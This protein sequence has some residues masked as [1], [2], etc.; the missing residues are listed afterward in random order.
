M[1]IGPMARDGQEPV[2]SMGDDLAARGALGPAPSLFA[3]FKQL[4][5]QVTNP[6]ID[7]VRE[8][9]VMSLRSALGTRATCSD[10]RPS[11]LLP[12]ARPPLLNG[13]LETPRH[14]DHTVSPRRSTSPGRAPTAPW[15]GG[16]ARPPLRARPRRDRRGAKILVLSDR[17]PAPARAP[18]PSLLATAAVHHHLVRE[19]TRCAP[20]SC[21]SGEPREAHHFACLVGFG[22][23]RSTRT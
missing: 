12:G 16:G 13:E 23:R 19:G 3:Y 10:E 8:E 14:V 2:G 7:P 21:E 9:I 20:G 18:I 4:F 15:A 6:P 5:A 22:A 11:T 1:L 17:S